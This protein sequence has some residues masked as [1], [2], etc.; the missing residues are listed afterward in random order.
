MCR[1]GHAIIA[2]KVE[3]YYNP[4]LFEA[5]DW[6]KASNCATSFLITGIWI[7]VYRHINASLLLIR[8]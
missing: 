5:S 7:F 8:D 4:A 1:L 2:L 6:W 3:Q